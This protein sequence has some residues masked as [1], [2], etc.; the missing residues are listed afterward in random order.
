M[1]GAVGLCCA[2]LAGLA[3][4]RQPGRWSGRACSARTAPRR[5]RGR[6]GGAVEA[7]R[8]M[9]VGGGSGRGWRWRL[10]DARNSSDRRKDGRV[11]VCVCVCSLEVG[12]STGCGGLLRPFSSHPP[13]ISFHAA[14][15][16][17]SARTGLWAAHAVRRIPPPVDTGRCSAHSHT[18]TQRDCL[19]SEPR[20][21][22][23]AVCAPSHF[24]RQGRPPS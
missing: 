9:G 21:R 14:P 10:T 18:H 2:A 16:G 22:L 11:D 8:K 7:Q 19:D 13:P 24:V 6:R 3:G 4:W 5:K 15:A 1:R 20:R 23:P 17:Q 12:G